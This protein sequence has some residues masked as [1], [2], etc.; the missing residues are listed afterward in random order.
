MIH[1]EIITPEK[2]AFTDEVDMVVAPSTMGTIGILP[3]H[4]PLFASLVEGE[5]KIKKGE[6]E[7]YLAIGGGF[8]QVTKT[9]VVVLVTRAVNSDELNEEE[10]LRAKN[11]AESKL[12]QVSGKGEREEVMSALRQTILDLKLINRRKRQIH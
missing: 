9:K 2:V 6:E 12:K 8:V 10:I 7:Y 4:I 1:L 3:K 5:V 11:E